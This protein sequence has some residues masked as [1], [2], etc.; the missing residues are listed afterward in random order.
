MFLQEPGWPEKYNNIPIPVTGVEVSSSFIGSHQT[1]Q[2]SLKNRKTLSEFIKL[3]MLILMHQEDYMLGHG[4]ER[5]QRSP[6]KGWVEE[7][8]QNWV[9]KPF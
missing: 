9:Y 6:D 2:V 3:L 4:Q 8:F 7:L 1:V 5:V